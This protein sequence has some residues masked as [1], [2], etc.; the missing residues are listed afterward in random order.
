V[1]VVFVVV[2]LEDKF[3]SLFVPVADIV[4]LVFEVVVVV[5][6]ETIDESKI[7]PPPPPPCA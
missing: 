2:A 3:D 4:L 7:G 6:A 1:G 5:E